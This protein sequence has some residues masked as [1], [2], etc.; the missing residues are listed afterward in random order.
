MDEPTTGQDPA[1]RSASSTEI[2]QLSGQGL[3][4]VLLTHDLDAVRT[5]ADHVIVMAGGRVV[6]TVTPNYSC[7][8]PMS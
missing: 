5:V 7:P 6:E 4:I 8:Q 2:T 1:N 3:T